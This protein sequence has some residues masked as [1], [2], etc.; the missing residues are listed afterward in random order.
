M[1]LFFKVKTSLGPWLPTIC[2]TLM[3]CCGT[4]QDGKKKKSMSFWPFEAYMLVGETVAQ[5]YIIS[6]KI[7]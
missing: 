4:Y 7:E 3:E 6:G 5:N 1:F 2:E